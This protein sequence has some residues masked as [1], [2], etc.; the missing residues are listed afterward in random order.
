MKRMFPSLKFEQE[1]NIEDGFVIQSIPYCK[2][3]CNKKSCLD[4]YR[5][6]QYAESGFYTCPKGLSAYVSKE[7]DFPVIYTSMRIK[8]HYEKKVSQKII[9]DN[10]PNGVLTPVIGEELFFRLKAYDTQA[11]EQATVIA[12]IKNIH[13]ELLHD[14]RKICAHIKNKS[15]DIIGLDDNIEE[16]CKNCNLFETLQRVKN[17]EALA[18]IATSRFDVY[19][20]SMNPATMCYGERRVRTIYKKFHKAKYMLTNYMEKGI[21]IILQGRSTFSYPIYQTFDALPFILLE[22]A[23]KYAPDGSA[24]NIIFREEYNNLYISIVSEGP[25]CTEDELSYLFTKGFR[26][27]G[28]MLTKVPG[29][30]VGLN[31]AKELCDAHDI[32]INIK[33]RYDHKIGGIPYGEFEVN[34][35]FFHGIS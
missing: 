1:N 18:S 34:L 32:K 21:N 17:I 19:D 8:G 5:K 4:F 3:N 7:N 30:G 25:T 35:S 29:N 28:A 22:N 33:S 6:L 13:A 26:G 16:I 10:L 11:I 9:S 14:I 2:K 27:S 20:I 23:V 12:N 15:E 24:V 31:L